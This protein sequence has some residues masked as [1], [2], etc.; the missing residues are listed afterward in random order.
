[1][2]KFA[3]LALAC[4]GMLLGSCSS[5]PSSTS[6]SLVQSGVDRIETADGLAT[7]GFV[8][9]SLLPACSAASPGEACQDPSV[10]AA[11]GQAKSILDVAITKAKAD[12][13]GAKDQSAVTIAINVALDAVAVFAKAMATYGVR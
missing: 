7:A 8:V 12:I 11:I 1:M 13:L 4:A 6:T 5:A 3:I 10:V 9:Y 2:R